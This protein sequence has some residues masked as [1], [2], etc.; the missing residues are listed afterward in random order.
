MPLSR[1][2]FS[3]LVASLLLPFQWKDKPKEKI[4]VNPAQHILELCQSDNEIVALAAQ[5]ELAR[6]L[7][8]PL[9]KAWYSDLDTVFTTVKRELDEN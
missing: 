8:E 9:K 5:R 2:Q 6:V 4:T 7:S 1:R 3:G